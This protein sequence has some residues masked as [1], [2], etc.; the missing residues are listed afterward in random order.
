MEESKLWLQ[1]IYVFKD[2][3][4][5]NETSNT[6]KWNKRNKRNISEYM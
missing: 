5:I 1:I 2:E 6:H 3:S 4:R